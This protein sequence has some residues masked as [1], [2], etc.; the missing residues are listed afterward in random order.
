MRSWGLIG[1]KEPLTGFEF[2]EWNRFGAASH[3]G[4]RQKNILCDIRSEGFGHADDRENLSVGE[5]NIDPVEGAV[6]LEGVER[7]AGK[8]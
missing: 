5:G 3:C 6:T 1:T 8:G 7:D 4:M 2:V